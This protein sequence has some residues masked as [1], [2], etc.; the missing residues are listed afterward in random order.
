MIGE[1]LSLPAAARRGLDDLAALARVARRAPELERTVLA[2]LDAMERRLAATQADIARLPPAAEP[3][4]AR[5]AAV[6]AGIAPV[7]PEIRGVRVA[8]E[9]QLG[10]VRSVEGLLEGVEHRLERLAVALD[11]LNGG[12]DELRARVPGDAGRGPLAR[13]RDA[14]TGD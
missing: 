11:R 14:V 3:L 10:A 8:A 9:S 4:D 7:A 5:L 13:A 1:L 2:R 6:E 12:L